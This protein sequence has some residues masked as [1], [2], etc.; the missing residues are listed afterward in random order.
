LTK[1]LTEFHRQGNAGHNDT[2]SNSKENTNAFV[3]GARSL[4]LTRSP[5]VELG[6]RDNGWSKARPTGSDCNLRK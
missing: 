5:A 6:S 3:L 2:I 4:A 1:P